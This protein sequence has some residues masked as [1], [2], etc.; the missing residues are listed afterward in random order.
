[1]SCE[2]SYF[3]GNCKSVKKR[4]LTIKARC[5]SK[6]ILYIYR[7][8]LSLV[9]RGQR[10]GLLDLHFLIATNDRTVASL[11]TQYLC[12]AYRAFKPLTQLICHWPFLLF[13]HTYFFRV[14]GWPQQVSLPSPALVTMNSELHFSQKY[15]LP[16]SFANLTPPSTIYKSL[17]I[18]ASLQS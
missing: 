13:L 10:P 1:M 2:K 11:N 8:S 9:R 7:R 12:L 6:T 18:I 3:R 17:I 4:H 14:I 15:L 5:L 16:T